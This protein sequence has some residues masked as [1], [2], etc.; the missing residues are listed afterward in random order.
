[1]EKDITELKLA[2]NLSDSHEKQALLIEKNVARAILN[3]L[4]LKAH[5]KRRQ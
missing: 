3:D 1:M 4:F 2:L 5:Y